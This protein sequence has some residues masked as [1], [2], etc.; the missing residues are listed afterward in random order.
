MRMSTT[1]KLIWTLV[2]IALALALYFA[3]RG[4]LAPSLLLDFTNSL[5]C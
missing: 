4:Y 2:A 3:F 5:L 1:Q